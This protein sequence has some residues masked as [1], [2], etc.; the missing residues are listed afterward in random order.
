MF[1]PANDAR[2]RPR[3]GGAQGLNQVWEY[4]LGIPIITRSYLTVCFLTTLAVHLDL[5]SPLKLY[6]RG[7]QSIVSTHEYWRFLTTFCFYDY[8]GLNFILHM[9]FLL[10]YCKFLEQG[11]FR[12][13]TGDFLFFC[14]FSSVMLIGLNY[15]LHY[16]NFI[17]RPIFF[18]APSLAF[19]IV[20][21]WARRN[22]HF[23]MTFLHLVN[24]T[25]PW[26]PWVILGFGYLMGNSPINDLLG[27]GVGHV[28]FYFVDIYP[29][30]SGRQILATPSIFHRLF[31]AQP[32]GD[33]AAQ[34]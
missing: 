31:D 22:P 21:L 25:A 9:F 2:Q 19:A 4:Y 10:R 8:I 11:S 5:V 18:L 12:N 15:L 34:Q 14:L 16:W 20:Y 28:Y 17:H 13:R 26:L 32:D 7:F 23:S 24:F 29:E 6:M 1:H 30:F 27:I 3:E 33:Q